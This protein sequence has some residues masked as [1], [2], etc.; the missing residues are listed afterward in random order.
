MSGLLL[1][2]HEDPLCLYGGILSDHFYSFPTLALPMQTVK[3]LGE[4]IG[5]QVLFGGLIHSTRHL[6]HHISL[7]AR[8]L[9]TID[10]R[11]VLPATV[12]LWLRL[13][14]DLVYFWIPFYLGFFISR[15]SDRFLKL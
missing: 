2:I 11:F 4:R 1:Y 3:D 13:D 15:T 7:S 9:V 14:M 5:G 8:L 10:G 12:P 6:K